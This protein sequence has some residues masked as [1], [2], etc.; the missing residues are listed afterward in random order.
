[1]SFNQYQTLALSF[2]V[3][4]LPP[5]TPRL[6]HLEWRVTEA[7]LSC[8][9]VSSW[10][11]WLYWHLHLLWIFQFCWDIQSSWS[12]LKDLPSCPWL[13]RFHFEKPQTLHYLLLFCVGSSKKCPLS[14]EIARKWQLLSLPSNRQSNYSV[15]GVDWCSLEAKFQTF[16][17]V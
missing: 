2:F 11:L 1:M 17:L 10:T 4:F 16:K 12:S 13:N 14:A 7:C 5:L 15:S 9:S 6:K 3:I 8:V